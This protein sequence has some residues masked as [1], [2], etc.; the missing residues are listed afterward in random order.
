MDGERGEGVKIGCGCC[1]GVNRRNEPGEEK[2]GRAISV[3]VTRQPTE[4]NCRLFELSLFS[5]AFAFAFVTR[6]TVVQ[7]S[8]ELGH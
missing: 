6:Y 8:H 5:A 7:K 2:G 1:G 4:I 3:L